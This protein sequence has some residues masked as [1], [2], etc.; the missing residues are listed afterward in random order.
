MNLSKQKTDSILIGALVFSVFFGASIGF[1][2]RVAGIV[3][4]LFR[5]AIPL[6]LCVFFYRAYRNKEL[7]FESLDKSFVILM[8]VWFIYSIALMLLRGTITD[9]DAF[10]E[11]L[12]MFLQFSIALCVLLAVKIEGMENRIFLFCKVSI[13]ALT[14]LGIFEIVTGNHLSTSSYYNVSAMANSSSGIPSV[15]TGIFFN[16]NDYCACLAL[17]SPLFFPQLGK[18]LYVNALNV[19]E[20]SL[21]EFLLLKDDAVICLFGICLGLL[22]YSI[23]S[24]VKYRWLIAGVIY[25]YGLEKLIMT[26]SL[27]RG[28]RGLGN[29]VFEQFSGVNSQTGSAYIRM[30]TYITEFTH[31]IRDAKGLGYGPYG[32]NKFLAPFDHNY[33][34]SNPHSLWLEIIANY[35]IGIFIFF[36]SICILSLAVMIVCGEKKD[37]VRAVLIPMDIIFVIVGFASSNY[38]GI[39]YWW[40]VIA[41]SVAYASKLLIAGGTRKSI[42]K[43]YIVAI[44]ALLFCLI[45]VAYAALTSSSVRY[46]FQL[47]L[48]PVF[49]TEASY[50]FERITSKGVSKVAV[51]FDGKEVKKLDVKDGK[52]TYEMELASLNEGWH[53]YRFDYFT[54]DGKE[55]GHEAYFVNKLD[56]RSSI[57]MP[58]EHIINARY[59]NRGM[60]IKMDDFYYNKK[61]SES[62]YEAM[63]PYWKPDEMTDKNVDQRVRFDK[64]GVPKIVAGEDKFEYDVDL[65]TSYALIWYTEAIE[66]NNAEARHRFISCTNWLLEHQKPDG[67]IPMMLG[68]RY[69]EDTINSGWVSAKAQGRALSVF[70]RA[71]KLT[72]DERYLEAGE[73]ALGFLNE[74]CLRNFDGSI[75][76]KSAF[77]DYLGKDGKFTYYEDYSN[78]TPHY[79]LD[80]QL[81]VLIGLYDWSQLDAPNSSKQIAKESYDKGVE[82]LKRTLPIYDLN[83]Y[84][85]GDLMHLSEGQLVALD[86]DDKFAKCIVMLKAIYEQSG[87]EKIKA[88]YGK[89]SNFMMDKFYKQHDVL[90][91]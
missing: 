69:R 1:G 25:A 90:L 22:I 27:K 30:N 21:M 20:L 54:D 31:S 62:K 83:G 71:Y 80:T 76:K 9:K 37:R 13:V 81:Y 77:T 24:M 57:L 45:V 46:K 44:V 29:E 48:K 6:L 75:D 72:G 66:D 33:V 88:F 16:E 82:M 17:F 73:K 60:H 63:G 49:E 70:A 55:S 74:K 84:L 43:K 5:V 52:F 39:A 7:K 79:R 50:R 42:K 11:L 15:A 3:V 2:F 51:V 18:K 32:V 59:F 65:T 53:Y 19:I 34:L 64:N 67:S 38:I 86:S 41:L 78:L 58:E 26:F 14:L 85:T 10:K 68:S 56:E 35:G 12:Q 47:P 23:V 8:A 61:L 89:Y 28:D 87:D 4:T 40:I 91:K 36:V